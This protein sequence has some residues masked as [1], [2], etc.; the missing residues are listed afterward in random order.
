MAGTGTQI[1]SRPNRILADVR[2]YVAIKTSVSLVTGSLI[3]LWLLLL[4]VDYPLLWGM[5]AF[6]FNFV[7]NIGSLIAAIPAVLLGLS[8]NQSP[9]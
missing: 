1:G 9:T 8:L 4:G 2:R 5:L 7:P 6:F 3:F